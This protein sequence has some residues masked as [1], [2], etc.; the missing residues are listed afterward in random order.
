LRKN[1]PE[2]LLQDIITYTKPSYKSS[3]IGSKAYELEIIGYGHNPYTNK[4]GS[5]LRCSC[6][7]ITHTTCWSEVVKGR[8]KRCYNCTGDNKFPNFI[9][10][11]NRRFS[12]DGYKLVENISDWREDTIKIECPVH[13]LVGS[14][15]SRDNLRR[16]KTPCAQCNEDNRRKLRMTTKEDFISRCEAIHGKGKYDYSETELLG[17]KEHIKIFCNDCQDYFWQVQDYHL[18]G[19][20]C[21]IENSGGYK[22]KHSGSLYVSLWDN[23]LK[24]GITN[25]TASYRK[26]IQEERSGLKG[27][28][29]YESPRLCGEKIFN[30][31]LLI[32]KTFDKKIISKDIFPD[33]H[34][35]CY[36][37]EDYEQILSFIQEQL[38][39]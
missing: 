18:Q 37:T 11:F 26:S 5:F 24:V 2:D 30:L 16:A 10:A 34:T 17:C 13:G 22:K 1:I 19:C 15:M 38:E 3:D 9:K 35:E 8:K 21:N 20:G 36:H 32:S 23:F 25:T 39:S 27:E 29:L 33:G 12:A 6:G 4:I 31:E 14:G 7:G 28:L